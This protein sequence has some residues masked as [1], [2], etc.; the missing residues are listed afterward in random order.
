MAIWTKRITEDLLSRENFTFLSWFAQNLQNMIPGL[1]TENW[2]SSTFNFHFAFPSLTQP[3]PN[4][5]NIKS[6]VLNHPKL[7]NHALSPFF[8]AFVISHPL[9]L[10]TA[11]TIPPRR[12]FP[13]KILP[14]FLPGPPPLL[15]TYT[16]LFFIL[17]SIFSNVPTKFF[18]SPPSLSLSLAP[19][20]SF[21]FLFTLGRGEGIPS[22]SWVI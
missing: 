14:F 9:P 17:M 3:P 4:P 1:K 7:P 16:L 20:P 13:F 11:N 8:F 15:L 22:I 10:Q 12:I 18:H 5:L 2:F 6:I 19:L 21:S